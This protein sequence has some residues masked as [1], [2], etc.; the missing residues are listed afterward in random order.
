MPRQN[1]EIEEHGEPQLIYLRRAH[2]GSEVELVIVE[3]G[4]ET[5]YVIR[6]DRL[7]RLV[8][9]GAQFLATRRS[10]PVS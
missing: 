8:A 10:Q 9:D 2:A 3:A 1:R 5:H 4:R 6:D 7:L